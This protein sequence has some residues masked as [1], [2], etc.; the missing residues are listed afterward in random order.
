MALR[1]I[2]QSDNE[3]LR[4]KSRDVQYFDYR[5]ATLLDDMLET[6]READGVGLAAPQVGILKRVIV[7][8]VGDEV[9]ELVNPKI[10]SKKGKQT[11]NEGCL[12]CPGIYGVVKRP[13]KVEIKAFNRRGEAFTVTGEELLARAFCHEIDHLDG[14]LFT[15]LTDEIY[16]N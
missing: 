9:L 4:K 14:I 12:S 15:D 8:N 13:N 1:Q 3:I 6:L 5:L 7:I 2:I 11:G 10:I 16:K